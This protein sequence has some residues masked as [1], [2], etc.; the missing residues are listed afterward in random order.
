[1]APGGGKG[2]VENI[3]G[4]IHPVHAEGGFETAL[5]KGGVMG[6][7]G[8]ISNDGHYL[9]PDFRKYWCVFRVLLAQA[10]NAFAEPLIVF[11]LRM[12]EAVEGVGNYSVPYNYH[13][14]AAYA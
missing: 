5:V 11:R 14:H 9:F 1:M 4:I 6:N 7:K 3:I 2:V 10:V 8:K 13:T 12:D